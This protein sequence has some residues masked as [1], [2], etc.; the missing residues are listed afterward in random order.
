M[1]RKASAPRSRQVCANRADLSA[2]RI[3]ARA[4]AGGDVC[5]M[6]RGHWLDAPFGAPLPSV[7]SE[8]AK[9]SSWS[10]KARTHPRR[11]NEFLLPPASGVDERGS[12]DGDDE[13]RA[14]RM[15]DALRCRRQASTARILQHLR[16]LAR[17][18]AQVVPARQNVRRSRAHLP[19]AR[20]SAGCRTRHNTRPI[21]ASSRPHRP[22]Q[23][24][25][26]NRAAVLM[27][28]VW[29]RMDPIDALSSPAWRGRIILRLAQAI[30][31]QARSETVRH[32]PGR[33]LE[34]ADGDAGARAEK[35]IR[36]ADIEAAA[37]QELVAFR[38]ARPSTVRARR[39]ASS[40]RTA[41]RRAAGRPGGRWRARR[42]PPDCIS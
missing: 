38:N 13:I 11:E 2:A 1:R 22:I 15:A 4:S 27:P 21:F 40:A 29:C 31:H 10:G 34:I 14:G 6:L 37:R 19:G 32:L 23:I 5:L 41:R 17:M 12:Y 39:A 28:S 42:L 9:F 26:R 35:P 18:P 7:L 33:G 16:I 3:R 24:A 30:E 25:R 8:D 20:N 36:L